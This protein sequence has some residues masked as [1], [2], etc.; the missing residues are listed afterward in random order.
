MTQLRPPGG[1]TTFYPAGT[2]R[3]QVIAEAETAANP[4][5]PRCHECN[6]ETDRVS[7]LCDTDGCK[8][9]GMK[10]CTYCPSSRRNYIDPTAEMCGECEANINDLFYGAEA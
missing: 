5:W 8:A 10:R 1:Q 9:Q 3:R 6:K 2:G 7:K 4:P